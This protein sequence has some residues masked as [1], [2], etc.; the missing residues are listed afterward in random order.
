M[1]KPDKPKINKEQEARSLKLSIEAGCSRFWAKRGGD[2]SRESS[3]N[4]G[5]PAK[6]KTL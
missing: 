2:P 1:K 5:D 4:Y 6:R 3:Y